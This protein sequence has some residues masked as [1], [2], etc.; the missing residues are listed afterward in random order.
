LDEAAEDHVDGCGE[1]GGSEEE[2]EGLEDVDAEACFVIVAESS[3]D[4]TDPFNF[5]C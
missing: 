1:E 4:V 5:K 3:T 2:C